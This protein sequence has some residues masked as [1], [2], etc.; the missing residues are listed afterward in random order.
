MLMGAQDED[1]RDI[2]DLTMLRTW[3]HREDFL[4]QTDKEPEIKT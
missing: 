1:R 2:I 4:E 3:V